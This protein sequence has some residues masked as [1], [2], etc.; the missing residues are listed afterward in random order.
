MKYR[1]D[2]KHRG[3][4][5]INRRP[6]FWS[7]SI[8]AITPVWGQ[9]HGHG[10]GRGDGRG[11]SE[12]WAFL[13]RFL[14]FLAPKCSKYYWPGSGV[15]WLH[16]AFFYWRQL[17]PPMVPMKNLALSFYSNKIHQH[18]EPPKLDF[19][20]MCTTGNDGLNRRN[21]FY[22]GDKSCDCTEPRTSIFLSHIQIHLLLHWL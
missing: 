1:Q 12:S 11:L 17:K 14:K 19:P 6:K 18:T 3:C 5:S 7:A 8:Q 15:W 13:L 4:R 22:Y 10:L 21:R 9:V 2:H 20:A 16:E